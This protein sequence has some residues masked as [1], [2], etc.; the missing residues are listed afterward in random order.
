MAKSCPCLL[1]AVMHCCRREQHPSAALLSEYLLAAWS[2]QDH[3]GAAAAAATGPEQVHLRLWPV[4]VTGRWQGRCQWRGA[5]PAA[6]Q[7]PPA[8]AAAERGRAILQ[9]D[10]TPYLHDTIAQFPQGYKI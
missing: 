4:G 7:Q 3:P 9:A 1:P 8:A 5:A 2:Q 6:V 10:A